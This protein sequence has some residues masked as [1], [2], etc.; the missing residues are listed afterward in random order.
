MGEIRTAFELFLNNFWISLEWKNLSDLSVSDEMVKKFFEFSKKKISSEFRPLT[1]FER[2]SCEKEFQVFEV[3]LSVKS[4]CSLRF[5]LFF[6]HHPSKVLAQTRS[7]IVH[8]IIW[9]QN[10]W[11]IND[12][13]KM[14]KKLPTSMKIIRNPWCLWGTCAIALFAN[15]SSISTVAV[16]DYK[17][18][19]IALAVIIC[20]HWKLAWYYYC[21][22]HSLR[23]MVW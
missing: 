22:S 2:H 5:Q 19:R 1:P 10:P 11:K 23:Q 14:L 8:T 15:G 20:S 4:N 3:D 21:I 16:I 13:P 6:F 7:K 18:T 17:K 9:I 12:F